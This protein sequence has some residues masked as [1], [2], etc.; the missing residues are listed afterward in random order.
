MSTTVIAAREILEARA[1][2]GEGPLWDDRRNALYWVDIFNHRVHRFDPETGENET[3]NVGDVVGSVALIDDHRILV[4]LRHEI[5]ELDTTSGELRR[6]KR[7]D[8]LGPGSRLNDGKCDA[9]G[10]FWIGSMST[11]EGEAQLFRY[12]PDGTFRVMETGLT[13]SNGLDWSP[14]GMTFYLTDSP[15]RR[16]YGYSFDLETGEISDR[17]VV[18][19]LKGESVPDGLTVDEEGCLWS[20]QWDGGCVIRFAPDGREIARVELPVP[21]PASCTF[22][23]RRMNELYVTS[24]SIDLTEEEIDESVTSGD[25]FCVRPG[26][27][28]R[29]PHRFAGR[30]RERPN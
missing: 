23:G 6:L 21:R 3:W 10:R 27:S 11:A 28:G 20:A 9:A 15:V 16:I 13:I 29:P 2:L 24:A 30:T 18:V 26:V 25:L 8:D 5:A 14:D 4:A 7:L 17:R 22:G 19:E 12:D 1:R